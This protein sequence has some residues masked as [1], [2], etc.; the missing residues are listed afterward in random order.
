M[1]EKFLTEEEKEEVARENIK[2]AYYFVDK[3]DYL[4]FSF[5]DKLS[6]AMLGMVKALNKFDTN[7]GIKFS[8][9]YGKIVHFEMLQIG[10]KENR[11]LNNIS[12]D[13][14]I[15]ESDGGKVVTLLDTLVDDK[16][17]WSEIN[18]AMNEVVKGLSTKQKEIF[19]LFLQGRR[20]KEIGEIVGVGQTRVS[21]VLKKIISD[22]EAEY[23]REA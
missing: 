11:H 4:P 14:P 10:E 7:K 3:Y 2:L 15:S 8:T 17:D 16:K 6:A 12:I 23:W 22:I 18:N 9:F 19:S 5:E 21:K 1:K 13:E 20:Q